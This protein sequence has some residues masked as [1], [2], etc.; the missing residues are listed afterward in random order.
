[1]NQTLA[2]FSNQDIKRRLDAYR[3]L[4]QVEFWVQWQRRPDGR[5]VGEVYALP[6]KLT[7][8]QRVIYAGRGPVPSPDA[9]A[10]RMADHLPMERA[11]SL[12]ML[13]SRGQRVRAQHLAERFGLDTVAYALGDVAATSLRLRQ[14][15]DDLGPFIHLRE[16]PSGEPMPLLLAHDYEGGPTRAATGEPVA[17][18]DER[19]Y[20]HPD[21]WNTGRGRAR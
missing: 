10:R 7:G 21:D 19:H 6:E 13:E 16:G 1:M 9:D 2:R 14:L 5:L 8:L 4:G 18:I 17:V 12:L 3:R 15:Y 20:P 11:R